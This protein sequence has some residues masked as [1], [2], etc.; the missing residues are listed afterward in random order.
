MS[1][2]LT[3]SFEPHLP[4]HQPG[5]GA[6]YVHITASAVQS[7]PEEARQQWNLTTDTLKQQLLY[8]VRNDDPEMSAAI[9]S[10]EEL[11]E[12]W[13]EV[14]RYHVGSEK[15]FGGRTRSQCE[16]ALKL[17][18]QN[19]SK[20]IARQKKAP[21]RPWVLGLLQ[22]PY[23]L[24]R[25]SPE[26]CEEKALLALRQLDD[27]FESCNDM[28]SSDRWSQ[29]IRRQE[30]V[31]GRRRPSD[32]PTIRDRRREITASTARSFEVGRPHAPTIEFPSTRDATGDAAP[33]TGISCPS[34]D[35][36]EWVQ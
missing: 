14:S 27:Q 6:S 32:P 22:S 21:S 3:R 33:I 5:I 29:Q 16:S 26:E 8:A 11:R 12:A 35:G 13:R 17:W 9:A 1:L 25:S 7:T 36:G 30:T 15:S 19:L 34:E 4:S 28:W 23:D 2:I 24:I 20:S 31:L 10:I 18:I